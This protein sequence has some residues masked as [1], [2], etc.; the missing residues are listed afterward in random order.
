MSAENLVESMKHFL[1]GDMP[2]RA[3]KTAELLEKVLEEKALEQLRRKF[4][5]QGIERIVKMRDEV[6][7]LPEKKATEGVR[8]MTKKAA[9]K[10]A[11]GK[12]K[13]TTRKKQSEASTKVVAS[14]DDAA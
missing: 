5:L 3:K 6:L 9:A 12:K 13:E 1:E 4:A 14:G 2:T 7:E 11:S 10:R 8:E